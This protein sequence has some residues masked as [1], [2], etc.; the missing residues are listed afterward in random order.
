MKVRRGALGAQPGF[1]V[2]AGLSWHASDVPFVL[3]SGA[4]Q[5]KW[6]TVGPTRRTLVSNDW[7]I[8]LWANCV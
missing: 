6:W 3:F 8:M 2:R 4:A 7:R 5:P 1:Y